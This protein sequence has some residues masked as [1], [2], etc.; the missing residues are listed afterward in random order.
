[1]CV[2]VFVFVCACDQN[3]VLLAKFCLPS[4]AVRTYTVVRAGLCGLVTQTC[5]F[6]SLHRATSCG[7]HLSPKEDVAVIR[8]R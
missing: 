6:H 2:C 3:V 4:V 8:V 1:M 5:L 7:Q